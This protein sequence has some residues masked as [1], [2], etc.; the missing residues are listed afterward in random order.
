MNRKALLTGNSKNVIIGVLML[1]SFFILLP[2]FI[3]VIQMEFAPFTEN[4]VIITTVSYESEGLEDGEKNIIVG[5][6]FQPP[7]KFGDK[8]YPAIISCHGFLGGIGKESMNRWSIELAKRG[9]VVLAIDLPGNGMSIGEI[10]MFPRED[11]E[12]IIIK[13]GIEYLKKLDFVDR[14]A[15]GLMGISY[16]GATVS[17]AAGVLGD[18]VDASISINGFTNTT[19][20]LI[21]DILP[22]ADVK[23]EVHKKYIDIKKVGDKEVTKDNIKEFLILYGIIRGNEKTMEDLIIP[24]TTHLD[25]EFLKK[26]DAVEYLSN[27][28]NDSML[29]LHSSRDGTFGYTNQ[30]GQGYE[31]IRA[32]NKTAYY[33]LIDDNHQLMDD[34]DYTSDY[35]I[36]NFFEEKLKGIDLG[37]DWDNDYE[38][39]SQKR[40]IELTISKEFGFMTLYECIICF[41]ISLI[42]AFLVISIIFY[43]KKIAIK[44]A[45]KEE[46]ILNIKKDNP[47][48]IDLSFG[49]GS[50]VKTVIFLALLYIIAYLGILGIG[51]GYFTEIMAGFICAAFYFVLFIT[52][53]YIPDQAEVDLWKKIKNKR[54]SSKQI[55]EK[56]EI[57]I[58]DVNSFIIL[59]I[60]LGIVLAGSFGWSFISS[61]PSFFKKP[62]EQIFRQMLLIGTT[63][64]ISGIL[65][66]IFIEKK[67]N[68]GMKI[69]QIEWGTYSL[70]K[71]Q[72]I[73]SI[74]FGSVLFLNFFFQWNIWAFYMKFPMIMGPHS[75]YYIYMIFAI[76]TF[77]G[78]IQLFVKILKEKFLKD[79][80]SLATSE[81]RSVS[82]LILIES[83]SFLLG[84]LIIIVAT[85]II[86]E[87]LLN[88]ELFGDLTILIV[89]LFVVLFIITNI[90][91]I[92]C[93]DR[94]VFGISVF[95]PLIFFTIIAFFLHI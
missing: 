54:Y 31:A 68:E 41:F 33:I 32:V 63:F 71:Y 40:D 15:I 53:Y 76:I 58:F 9:F 64:L 49:R 95:L 34:P 16:G 48:F 78:G 84:I 51:L 3:K 56:N 52:L 30:S 18:K 94:G 46:K 82:K 60:V 27:V 62:F 80:I 83:L 73:K 88:T 23:F 43:N 7:P 36:I 61:A 21:E 29:F 77:F 22:D 79:N 93:V 92:F 67:Q 90:I 85:Y 24:G 4:E 39:Y 1:L 81:K 28:K 11:F 17:I 35:I 47:D 44:R 50:Y 86:F 10:D 55:I 13:D 66:I 42:P 89:E 75:I 59:F 91:K 45:E 2:N 87:P 14:T 26:F 38:K 37:N 70:D 6:L 8:R 5:N 65:L 25:R 74:T 69:N 12:P 20:W 19:N 72:L 57:K